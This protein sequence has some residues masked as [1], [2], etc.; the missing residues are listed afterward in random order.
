MNK[1]IVEFLKIGTKLFPKYTI[2][3][4]KNAVIAGITFYNDSMKEVAEEYK[5]KIIE[6]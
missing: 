1:K 6:P 5:P 4:T 3:K 2:H